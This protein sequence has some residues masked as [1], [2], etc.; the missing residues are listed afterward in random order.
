M[1]LGPLAAFLTVLVLGLCPA[2]TEAGHETKDV[3]TITAERVK[4]LLDA[5]EKML[6]I[7]LRSAKEFQ[8]K[9]LPR[10]TLIPMAELDKRLAEIP[11][12][13]MV[14]VYSATP[15]NEIMDSVFQFF[16]DNGYRNVAFMVEGF[17]GWV[18]RK[19]PIETGH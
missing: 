3:T 2:V 6:L 14:I 5:G 19:Y 8:Q 12:V 15:Q 9:R 13:G 16:E 7:D 4:F 1:R 18:R 10:S 11:K 17:Q